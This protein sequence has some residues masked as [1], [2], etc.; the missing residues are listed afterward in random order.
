MRRLIVLHR[1]AGLMSG[2]FVLL[3]AITGMLLNHT[4][5]LALD[6]MHIEQPGILSWYG[7]E[8]ESADVF[9][10]ETGGEWVTGYRGAV[11]LGEQFL[12]HCEQLAGAGMLKEEQVGNMIM[13]ACQ[14]KLRLFSAEGELIEVLDSLVN[15]E[16][17]FLLPTAGGIVVGNTQQARLYDMDSMAFQLLEEPILLPSDGN[18]PQPHAPPE[19]YYSAIKASDHIEK[20]AI[21]L[22]RFVLDLHSGRILGQYGVLFF[23]LI[24]LVLVFLALS[25]FFVWI[26]RKL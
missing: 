3:V 23:D 1:T 14:D 17:G 11:F 19:P 12:F 15:F 10:V 21:P 22:E 16:I 26:K 20:P 18:G 8:T 6:S 13:I 9:A 4:E 25:G 5:E 24:A 7:I 2:L